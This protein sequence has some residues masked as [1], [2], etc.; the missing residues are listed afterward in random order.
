MQL[1]LARRLAPAILIAVTIS[2]CGGGSSS[3]GIA[4]KPPDQI[5]NAAFAAVQNVKSV[6]MA[7]TVLNQGTT[8]AVDLHL[9]SGVG[10]KGDVSVGG[11]RLHIIDVGQSVYI[12]AGP[13][14]WQHFGGAA[15]ANLLQGR[16]L[17]APASNP[18]FGSFSS[19]TDLHRLFAALQSS[20][21]ALVK[22]KT[23]TINGQQSIGLTDTSKGGT[24]YVATTGQPYPLELD[25]SAGGSGGR[26][27][28]DRYN[29]QVSI[30]PPANAIDISRLHVP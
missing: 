8:M 5:A 25:N 13:A 28:F 11:L 3:N 12:S 19:L 22:G 27:T 18:S 9:A 16:W 29:E 7:G 4:S 30:T 17:K 21:G 1:H 6:H 20:H 15:A 24:L 14:F 2:A 10:A 23:R 26:I